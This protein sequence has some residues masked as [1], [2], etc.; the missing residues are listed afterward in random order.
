MSLLL[1]LKRVAAFTS[2]FDFTLLLHFD[3]LLF[4][5]L[6][7]AFASFTMVMAFVAATTAEAV[8]LLGVNKQ[9]ATITSAGRALSRIFLLLF[10]NRGAFGRFSDLLSGFAVLVTIN[11]E[12]LLD[13][14][15]F[16]IEAIFFSER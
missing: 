15:F 4:L 13:A 5:F 3:I 10:L 16:D 9:I 8:L 11:V 2:A 14:F 1:V 12:E 7:S 6:L